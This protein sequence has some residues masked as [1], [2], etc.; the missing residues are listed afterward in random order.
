MWIKPILCA[1]LLTASSAASAATYTLDFTGSGGIPDSFG[2]NAEA[3]LS[4]RGITGTGFGDVATSG[5]TSFWGSGYGD[6]NGAIW[7]DN[8]GAH[9]EIR[10][11]AVNPLA[12]VSIDSFDMGGWSANEAASWYIYDLNW[13]LVGSG[14][15]IAPN[16][17]A[18]LSVLSGASAIGGLIFQ[19]G[20][21][22]WDVGVENFTYT[23]SSSTVPVPASVLLMG[24]ALAGLAALRRRG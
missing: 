7:A 12:M 10:I 15:G 22:A 17:G 14:T 13:T 16:T 24:G 19:W 2:D 1:G 21:D 11:A 23:V 4:Y 9:G 8:D 20:D 6:L 18:H 5:G 3:D